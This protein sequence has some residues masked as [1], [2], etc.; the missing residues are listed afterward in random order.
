M[1][2]TRIFDLLPYYKK[3]FPPGEVVLGGKE[4][5]KWYTYSIDQYQELSDL[6]SFGLLSIGIGKGDAVATVTNNRPEWNLLDIGIMQIGAVH[7]PVYP[8]VSDADFQYILEHGEVKA[9]FLTGE[10]LFR[11]LDR[12]QTVGRL[13]E[14]AYS[15][16][17]VN[18]RKSLQDLLELGRQAPQHGQLK[19]IKDSL[20]T[21]DL[22]TLI[23][24][25]GTT[26][27]P[28]G[29]MLTHANLISNFKGV[30]HIPQLPPGAKCLS[31]LP[32]SHVYERMINYTYQYLGY[33][34]Y[35]VENM[36]T[37]TENAREIQP[38]IM[39]AV[40]RF[41]EKVFEK[42]VT[43]G[44]KLPG[45]KKGIFFRALHLAERYALD[46]ANG[47]FYHCK[48][49]LADRLVFRKWRAALGSKLRIIVSGGAALQPRLARIFRAAGFE[50]LE[51]Y[52]LTE[53]SPVIAVSTREKG[54][55][56]FGCVGPVL[57][58]VQVRI[59]DDGEVLCK[60]PNV[61]SGYYKD[62]ALTAEAIDPEGWFHTGDLGRIE[63]NGH[64]RL[65]GRK[66]EMFKTSFG[67]YIAP[68]VIESRMK[69][70]SFIDNIMVVGENQKYPGAL[71]VPNFDHLRSWCH[72]KKIP[73][74]TDQEMVKESVIINRI[75]REINQLNNALGK[76]EQIRKFEI[77]GREWTIQDGELT[78]SLK[79]R[80]KL[81]MEKYR[82]QIESLFS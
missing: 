22:V 42:I 61:M 68:Q 64:L 27:N 16:G 34:I 43:T 77:L 6:V 73:F 80:R 72:I 65:I 57:K 47:W 36:A 55:F 1:E 67:K 54:G 21:S 20:S 71:I 30:S 32:L 12:L 31:F 63:P 76:S 53:T 9:I 52:G 2:I 10:E 45:I 75:A 38:E 44:R 5:G 7:V 40:P 24:T 69:E 13:A 78:P 8:T 79:L 59:A 18:G 37:I 39:C 60:G 70:S 3:H 4:N 14:R 48:L 81:I 58:D 29:V 11:K 28:K 46:R 50:V 74:T 25:S 23:Y 62:P 26:G 15:L 82:E 41:L 56:S 19:Q 17:Q 49:S 51:G 33:R 66:K 35:Y